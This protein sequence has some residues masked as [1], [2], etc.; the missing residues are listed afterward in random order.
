MHSLR[1]LSLKQLQAVA[2]VARHGTITK[3]AQELRVTPA[4]LT[5]RIKQLESEAGCALFD[6]TPGGLLITDP[7]REVLSAVNS[8]QTI[9][10]TCAERLNAAK[11]MTGGHVTIGVVSTAKYYAPR[12]IAAFAKA[13]PTIEIR[14]AVG[15]RE[16]TIKLLRDRDVD[17][18]IMGRPPKDFA[19]EAEAFGKHPFVFISSPNNRLVG[20]KNL[21]KKDLQGESFLVRE[22]GSG[23]RNI[24]EQ[25]TGDAAP[26]RPQF[27]VEIGSNETIKQAVMAELG[28]AL[29][30]AHTIA[31][32]VAAGRLAVLDVKGFPIWRQW[33][34]VRRAD[35]TFTLPAKAFWSFMTKEGKNW[36]P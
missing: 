19:V 29:I 11:G 16:N 9:I 10:E 8:I 4:A 23:T 20:R 22:G 33:F 28:V 7:G 25:F 30:S 31:T 17:I 12:A 3:A 32:E 26:R 5:L 27:S 34:A 13:N 1:N 18:A 36:L 21:T 2:A 6:R 15:N 35:K 24:F 14:L